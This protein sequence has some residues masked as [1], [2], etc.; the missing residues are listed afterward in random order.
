MDK[1]MT[2]QHLIDVLKDKNKNTKLDLHCHSD[3]SDGVKS[4]VELMMEAR[5]N[6]VEVLAITD[7]D[8]A[9]VF[10]PIAAGLVNPEDYGV[11]V[12][13]GVE[14]TT[15]T[16]QGMVE[17]LM[18]GF[19]YVKFHD[20]QQSSDSEFK[21]LTREFKLKRNFDVFKQRLE[22]ARQFGVITDE[23]ADI[24]NYIRLTSPE[25][26][27]VPIPFIDFNKGE[28][29]LIRGVDGT[30][31]ANSQS[32]TFDGEGKGDIC[33]NDNARLA[34][35]VVIDGNI[36]SVS[37]DSFNS[38]LFGAM[39]QNPVGKEYLDNFV[40]P[41]GNVGVTTFGDFLRF[42]TQDPENPI[43]VS[44]EGYYPSIEDNVKFGHSVGAIVGLAHPYNY[45]QLSA[46]PDAI[47]QIA[48]DSGVDFLECAYGFATL[49]QMN[50]INN[51]ANSQDR[52]ILLTGGTDKH[53]NFTD[54][55]ETTPWTLGTTVRTNLEITTE[56]IQN[57]DKIYL[58]SQDLCE[59]Q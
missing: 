7:H 24:R 27:G 8:T 40:K 9:K 22:K 21:F 16:E 1:L 28:E 13:P 30:P 25:E 2:A 10:E 34:E 19:D 17:T 55:A 57:I 41:D 59:A 56:N 50:H 54:V 45:P 58:D 42:V 32:L 6:G 14:I 18:Y 33:H 23:Q 38:K 11:K 48:I 43:Y 29:F 35:T 37:Y 47:M 20:K 44:P 12:V 51:V 5:E 53:K 39:K 46:T 4:L 26:G 3:V 36:Y 49:E 52:E 15:Y 31:V